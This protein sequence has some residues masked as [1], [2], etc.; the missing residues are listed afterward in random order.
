MIITVRYTGTCAVCGQA[1][2]ATER[3]EWDKPTRTLRHPSCTPGSPPEQTYTLQRY[4]RS[5]CRSWSPGQTLRIDRSKSG[6]EHW[7][8]YLTILRTNSQ[9]TREAGQFLDTAQARA[10]TLEEIALVHEAFRRQQ[11][12]EAALQRLQTLAD[13]VQQTGERPPGQH[14]P[15]GRRCFNTEDSEGGGNWWI[16]SDQ[17]IWYILNNGMDGDDW[18]QNNI[19]T[20]GA[21]AIGW[22]L[23]RTEALLAQLTDIWSSLAPHAQP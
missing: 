9:A 15:Q 19:R 2:Q 20:S 21:G 17:W 10:A 8:E 11:R 16:I 1:I 23:P 7:P 22:R 13:Q 3:A 6:R 18:S 12:R 4:N 14:T 5:G